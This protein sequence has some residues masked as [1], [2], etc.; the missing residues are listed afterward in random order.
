MRAGRASFTASVVA[1]A[2]GLD[3]DPVA[4]RLLSRPFALA[5]RGLR[6]MLRAAPRSAPAISAVTAG[7]SD[8]IPLR[9]AEIDLAVREAAGRG[10]QQVVILGAGLDARAYRMAELRDAVVFEVDQEATQESKRS[11][12]AGHQP[13]AREV[14]FV[15]VDFQRDRVSDALEQSGHRSDL[16]TFWI[17]EGVTP[18]LV[19]EAIRE[20]LAQIASRSAPGSGLAVT[21]A[22]PEMTT[23]PRTQALLRVSFEIIGEPLSGLIST[24]AMAR[25]L[26]AVGFQVV[27]D[28]GPHDWAHSQAHSRT[29]P[30]VICERLTVA[31]RPRA[32]GG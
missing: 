22:T 9:T 11:G 23:V 32:T 19:P 6:A 5:L 3:G 29:W 13:L 1:V 21:Y 4:E 20:T 30:L 28:R 31:V 15:R 14:R 7:L 26:E 2:R 24:E 12:V 18:Y 25:Q 17:W 27:S 16:P 8:H 10:V